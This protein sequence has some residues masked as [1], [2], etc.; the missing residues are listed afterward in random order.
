MSGSGDSK[1]RETPTQRVLS[2]LAMIVALAVLGFV[3]FRLY[4]IYLQPAPEPPK[5]IR[6]FRTPNGKDV[7]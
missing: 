3:A 7:S 4:D 1:A 5:P 6:I 2:W